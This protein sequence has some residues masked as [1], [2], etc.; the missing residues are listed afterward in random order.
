M[1]VQ[2]EYPRPATDNNGF[3]A[4]SSRPMPERTLR[5]LFAGKPATIVGVTNSGSSAKRLADMGFVSGA[6]IEMVRPGDPCLIRLGH[7]NIGL[8]RFHQECILI[9]NDA[10]SRFRSDAS[11]ENV[12]PPCN[13]CD[14]SGREDCGS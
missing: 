14:I 4:E 1:S 7:T 12:V 10:D 8:G 6:R 11:Y 5:E 3:M 2:L 13:P 9:A